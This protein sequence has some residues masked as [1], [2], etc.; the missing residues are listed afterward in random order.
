M[1][2][3]LSDLWDHRSP[4]IT[5]WR[6]LPLAAA[7]ILALVVLLGACGSNGRGSRAVIGRSL[8]I[9]AFA[10]EL[11]DR[12]YYVDGDGSH[13]VIRPKASNRQLAL[14]DVTVVNRTSLVTPLLINPEAARLG[15]RR[16]E[17][18]APGDP[19]EAAEVTEPG[20]ED[21]D[22]FVP[23][24]WGDVQLDKNSQVRGWMVFDVPKGLILGS[25]WWDEVDPIV[26]DYI[27]YQ[28]G[29]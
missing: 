16:G 5:L 8:E 15:D 20:N 12:V 23:F 29:R 9:R 28:R 13:R 17:R 24:L 14:V 1:G 19:F 10:P 6:I 4:A 27:D 2:K 7:V 18:I 11:V 22:R 3:P 26:V 25:L 21:E